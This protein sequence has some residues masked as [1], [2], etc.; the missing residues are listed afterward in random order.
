[1]LPTLSYETWAYIVSYIPKDHI[2][3]LYSINRA[4]YDI[5]MGARYKTLWLKY[6][7]HGCKASK[8]AVRD[9]YISALIK[10]EAACISR[11]P[12][13]VAG[14]V[15]NLHIDVWI[16]DC[17]LVARSSQLQQLRT[18]FRRLIGPFAGRQFAATVTPTTKSINNVL[19]E[20]LNS[21]RSLRS[22]L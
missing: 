18:R 17:F 1:M 13:S 10:G 5:S 6:P 3:T 8:V 12:A 21:M 20:A 22:V 9:F 7:D 4:L 15:Q 14:R 11:D 19:L 16:L 2:E